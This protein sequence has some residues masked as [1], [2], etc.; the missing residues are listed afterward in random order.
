MLRTR[1]PDRLISDLRR[2]GRALRTWRALPVAALL[3]VLAAFPA[4]VKAQTAAATPRDNTV[5]DC[6]KLLA[7]DW[8]D[9]ERYTWKQICAGQSAR[10]DVE[11]DDPLG[12]DWHDVTKWKPVRNL[13]AKFLLHIM[14]DPVLVAAT[15]YTGIRIDGA[16]FHEPV[17]LADLEYDKPLDI[18]HS[19]FSGPLDLT[20]YRSR[21]R[22]SLTNN[23]FRAPNNDDTGE[24]SLDAR[25]M[26][27]AKGLD[28]V[29]CTSE[30]D[31]D[32]SDTVIGGHVVLN[33]CDF[34]TRVLMERARITGMLRV[35]GATIADSFDLMSAEIDKNVEI[36]DLTIG[37]TEDGGITYGDLIAEQAHIGGNFFVGS[38]TAEINWPAAM[39]GHSATQASIVEGTPD[40]PAES[41]TAEDA[42]EAG[43]PPG[44][45]AFETDTQMEAAETE[46]LGSTAGD[47]DFSVKVGNMNFT[48]AQI[49]SELSI[50]GTRI[51]GDLS[52]EDISIGDDLWLLHSE[53]YSLNG[54]AMS[55]QGYVMMQ[56]LHIL[57][58][59][60]F[61]SGN[62]ERT[63]VMDKR[64]EISELRMLGAA[65]RGT[66]HFHGARILTRADL[67]GISVGQDLRLGDD[68][69]INGPVDASFARI[70]GS[71]DLTG[72]HFRVV[73]LRSAAIDG[74]L[75]LGDGSVF[76]SAI[77]ARFV[78]VRGS[79]DLTRGRF[80]S[81]DL[82][83]ATVEAEL[84]LSA[85]DA[86]PFFADAAELTLRNATTNSLQAATQ[87]WPCVLH[88]EGFTYQRHVHTDA[89]ALAA[90]TVNRCAK[91]A[92]A[93]AKTGLPTTLS[94]SAARHIAATPPHAMK[95]TR[96]EALTGWLARQEPFSPQ[97][98]V[99]LAGVLRQSGDNETAKAVLFAGKQREWEA[100]GPWAKFLLSLQFLFTGFGLYPYVAFGWVLGLIASGAVIFPLDPSEEVRRLSGLQRTIFSLDMLIPAVQLRHHHAQIELKSWVRYYLY[101]HKLMGYLLL[102]F[103]A[104]AILGLGGLG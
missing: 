104:A 76:T 63:I 87:S 37:R 13:S 75:M 90:N 43:A 35:E 51:D 54:V 85:A 40:P 30:G 93:D 70:G 18:A 23:W 50:Q 61:D 48:S 36:E 9:G 89:G 4:S 15:P 78:H 27:V 26:E 3:V 79:L 60:R 53:A 73:G 52:L 99:Q 56:G 21:A 84:R 65:V 92:E 82:T 42:P 11:F 20:R 38:S 19:V 58:V 34:K 94:P 86:V 46:A 95:V 10:L 16:H 57:D 5:S 41:Q 7:G 8:T 67:N 91:P 28:L 39:S 81:V 64:T 88:L 55:V 101:G 71:L 83:G 2:A 96:A 44:D 59:L 32:L 1:F 17:N 12:D 68:T 102:S 98:Y 72:G 29:G 14:S 74:D 103:L 31:V 97:P 22:L 45:A 100:A 24:I 33:R 66:I 69:V 47:E 6:S 49:D 25:G 62:F 80:A 77:D